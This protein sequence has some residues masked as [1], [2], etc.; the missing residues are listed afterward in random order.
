M[1]TELSDGTITIRAYERGIERAVFEAAAESSL[2]NR[3]INE[4]LAG[5]RHV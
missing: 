3:S 4:D 1:R 5:R 2:G